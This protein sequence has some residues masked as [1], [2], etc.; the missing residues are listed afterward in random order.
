VSHGA[1]RASIFVNARSL[2]AHLAN[3]TIPRNAVA[4]VTGLVVPLVA[5]VLAIAF[6]TRSLDRGEVT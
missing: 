4:P 6:T 3:H 5:T 2:A 1:A